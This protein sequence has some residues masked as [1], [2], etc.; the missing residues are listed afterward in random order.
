MAKVILTMEGQVLREYPLAKERTTIGRRPH[1]DIVIENLAISGEHA[2][3]VTI[4]NDSFLEDLGSTNGTMV[5]GAPVKK[6]FLQNND[7]IE[8]GKYRIRYLVDNNAPEFNTPEFDK[9]MVLRPGQLPK[10]LLKDALQESQ[11]SSP[12]KALGMASDTDF[13]NTAPANF[14]S[15]PKA[16]PLN[17]NTLPPAAHAAMAAAR[18]A[19]AAA[20]PAPAIATP[21]PA[22]AAAQAAKLAQLQNADTQYMEPD[23]DALFNPKPAAKPKNFEGKIR[24]LSGGNSG[25]EMVLIKMVTTIGRPGGQVAVISKK[26]DGFYVSHVE[27]TST[28]KVNGIEIG[29]VSTRLASA[30]TV[31]IAGVKM[32]FLLL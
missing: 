22:I 15:L 25:K 9:T 23:V 31:E 19:Q 29:A 16:V 1:N 8:L 20:S 5:N 17:I 10:E 3:I 6:H 21:S 14:S 2:V 24:I 28:P 27:G 7:V 12:A 30:D 18:A 4:L 32:E 11:F 13:G 26:A